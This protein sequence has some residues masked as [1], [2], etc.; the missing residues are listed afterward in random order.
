VGVYQSPGAKLKLR[1][2]KYV[3]RTPPRPA[4]GTWTLAEVT[5]KIQAEAETLAAKNDQEQ[6]LLCKLLA[7]GQRLAPEPHH[8]QV[9]SPER[10]RDGDGCDVAGGAN[11]PQPQEAPVENEASRPGEAPNAE[12]APREEVAP[13]Q[14]AAENS[15]STTAEEQNRQAQTRQPAAHPR[16]SDLGASSSLQRSTDRLE[17]LEEVVRLQHKQDRR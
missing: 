8:Q 5:G 1:K 9:E 2:R 14:G 10:R 15:S 6:C 13:K 12:D 7:D 17:L 4:E 16:P 3:G 11:K